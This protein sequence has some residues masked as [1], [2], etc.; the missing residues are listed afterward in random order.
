MKFLGIKQSLFWSLA[1]GAMLHED[2]DYCRNQAMPFQSS[3]CLD[4]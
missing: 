1:A 4:A 3:S 2:G